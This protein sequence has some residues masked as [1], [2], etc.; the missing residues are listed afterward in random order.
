ME[1]IE[2][3]DPKEL[4]KLPIIGEQPKTEAEEK[5]LREIC[6]YEFINIEESG[7]AIKFPYGENKNQKNITLLHGGKYMMPRF[8]ARHI[9]STQTPIYNWRPDGLGSMGKEKIGMKPRFQM[10]QTFGG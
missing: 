4:Q 9:E 1:R 10:R 5:Y 7:V 8:L 2:Q 3:Q 6:Q